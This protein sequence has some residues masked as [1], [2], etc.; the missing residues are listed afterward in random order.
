MKQ[1]Q[2]FNDTKSLPPSHQTNGP[3]IN[4]TDGNC[5]RPCRSGGIGAPFAICLKK[6]GTPA[7]L[8]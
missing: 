6:N 7:D 4:Y 2:H 8:H 1:Q 5:L 3:S